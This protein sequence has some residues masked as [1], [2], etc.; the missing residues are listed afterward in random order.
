MTRYARQLALPEISSAQQERLGASHI[1]MVGAGGLGA[2][3]LPYLA[4]AGI[5]KITI[6]DN[7]TVSISN[8]HRQTIYQDGEAGQGKAEAAAQYCRALNPDIEVIAIAERFDGV[9]PSCDLILDGSDNFETKSALNEASIK[10]GVPLIAA[11]VNQWQGQVGVFAG[12]AKGGPCYHCLFP[13]L[14]SDARNCNE[15]GILGTSAG[16]TGMW[17]AHMALCFLLGLENVRAGQVLSFDFKHFRMQSVSLNKDENCAHCREGQAQWTPYKA[18]NKMSELISM[19]ELAKKKHLIVD[20]RTAGEIA[21]DPIEGALHMEVSTVPS[22]YDELP[23]DT[24][25]AFV[26]AGNVRSVQAVEYLSALGFDNVCV[27]DK[28]S[29]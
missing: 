28:F 18:E 4:A 1:V 3:A 26:C 16:L 21:A 5:G 29:I 8:L 22:R 9:L 20:V 17:Q 15:A 14:P 10:M 23:R 13:E 11:S 27:L 2:A 6:I 25:L 12:F 7:D 24:L 19:S